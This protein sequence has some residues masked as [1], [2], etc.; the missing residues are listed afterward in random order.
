MKLYEII[1]KPLSGFG[2]PLKGDTIFGQFCWQA[3][4]TAD[5]LNGGLDHWITRYND[6][7][8]AVF[9]SAWP[10]FCC[11]GK[12]FYALKRPDLPLDLLFPV[13]AG[14]KRKAMADRKINAAKSWI[15]V[16]EGLSLCLAAGQSISEQDLISMAVNDFSEDTKRRL[17]GKGKRSLK[18]NFI[19]SHNTINRLTMTTGEGIFAPYTQTADFYYPE[20]ELALFVLLDE[21]ATD[22]ERV[23]VGLERI[24]QF[25]FGKDASIGWG[26]FELGE[27]DGIPLPHLDK[28]DACYTLGPAIP[29]QHAFKEFFFTPF[30][31]FG[32]HGD[33][34]A[35][36]DNP[37]KN[38]VIMSDE[39]AVFV[40][41]KEEVFKKPYLGRPACRVSK[42]LPEA[43]VQGYTPYLP[44][45]LEA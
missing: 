17:R 26:R 45:K 43:V 7:P 19:Q 38:P 4:Y 35:Q 23:R 42:A 9:S 40:P 20:M 22:I 28:A 25:G 44:F 13:P 1:L 12:W 36:S 32:R 14:D 31:R 11:N 24:G 10:K 37:F 41:E 16:P 3:A 21:E 39:G 30:T 18:K 8:F 6:Q 15:L 2:T 27:I 5:L 29:Q 33:V 34:L